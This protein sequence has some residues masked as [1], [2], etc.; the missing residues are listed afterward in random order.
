MDN[1]PDQTDTVCIIQYFPQTVPTLHV[2]FAPI[3]MVNAWKIRLFTM[4]SL[5]ITVNLPNSHGSMWFNVVH[6]LKF[7]WFDAISVGFLKRHGLARSYGPAM[8]FH[9]ALLSGQSCHVSRSAATAKQLRLAAQK[10][11]R[12]GIQR[13][14]GQKTGGFNVMGWLIVWVLLIP[15]WH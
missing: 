6:S 4:N 12:V 1:T 9:V 7:P 15:T 2:F 3:F 10:A 5:F 13:W 11:R 14:G 8:A